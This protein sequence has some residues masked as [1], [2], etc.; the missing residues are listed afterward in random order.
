MAGVR[1][2]QLRTFASFPLGVNNLG[3]EDALPQD[4]NGNQIALRE[5]VNVDT[6]DEGKP[7]LRDGYT[8]VR[9]STG[10]H[11][12]WSDD[13]LPFGLMV[14]NGALRVVHTDLSS[15]EL[16]SPISPGLPVSYARVNDQVF[17]T[18]GIQSG[19]VTT[20]LELAPWC[21]PQPN[22]QPTLALQADGALDA[23]SYQ[24]AVTFYDGLGRESGAARAVPIEVPANGAIA[25]SNIP[26]P[27]TDG[28][29]RL[30]CTG[31]HDGAL[32]VAATLPYGTTEYVITQRPTGRPC[33][34]LLLRPMPAGQLVA[35][36]N[37]RQ[38]VAR[39][40]ELLFS[41]TMRYGMIAPAKN[42]VSFAKRIDMIAFVG[43]GT[44]GAGL[45]VSDGSRT[46]FMAG[47]DPSDWRQP[48]AYPHG[49]M[50]G[51]IAYMS[52]AIWG[53]ATKQALPV[54]I[55]RNGRVVVGL[56]GGDV[57]LPQPREGGP[58]AVFDSADS[59]AI[60]LR[61]SQGDSRIVAALKG[62]QPNKLAV[63]DRL[64]VREYRH[65]E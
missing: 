63:S 56:P 64:I 49:A 32:R 18:N 3:A 5:G 37:G 14:D 25:L 60:Y 20:S 6:S 11:S 57:H 43:D 44:D 2:K 15:D 51:Q 28:R 10:C 31:G 65:G 46:Y 54:W 40:K 62:A 12:G 61:Q 16:V 27:P 42:R 21:C 30:Y 23:G 26:Q 13:Y 48:I 58:D 19:L 33:N 39:G 38:F 22:G 4:Q 17:W 36:G 8:L 29:I 45:F 34:T 47:A 50:P 55:A 1:D 35:F 53:L 24:V 9:A 41:P 59:A 52:G 7:G